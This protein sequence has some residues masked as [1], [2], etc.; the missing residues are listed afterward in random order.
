VWGKLQETA[1]D[2]AR[3]YEAAFGESIEAT[4]SCADRLRLAAERQRTKG[5]RSLGAYA[6]G[7]TPG[8]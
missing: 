3:R 1:G 5:R 8:R 2:V 7:V 4:M 6:G